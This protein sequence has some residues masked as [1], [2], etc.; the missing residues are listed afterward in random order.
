[1]IRT[2]LAA[3]LTGWACSTAIAAEA[4][5]K[6]AM[7]MQSH[8]QC[9]TWASMFD[10]TVASERHFKAGLEAGGIFIDAAMAGTIT[11]EDVSKHVPVM[12]SLTMQ[13]PNKEFVLGRLFESIQGDAYDRI[14]TR[15]ANGLP[16]NPSAYITDRDL[17]RTLTQ[18]Q[19]ERANCGLL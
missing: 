17:I 12:V 1:M 11:P 14:T 6:K 19:Y 2:V 9:F 5:A 18:T 8:W 7:L 3:L 13:G 4:D 16:L 15:E 10:D